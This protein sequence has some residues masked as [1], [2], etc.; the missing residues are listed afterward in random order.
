MLQH[1]EKIR[2]SKIAARLLEARFC[3]QYLVRA[4]H[5]MI[6]AFGKAGLR[7]DTEILGPAVSTLAHASA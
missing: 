1:I 3:C 6:H 4:H 2:K 5:I 7:S